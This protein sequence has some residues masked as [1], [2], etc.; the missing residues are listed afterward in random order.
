MS[1]SLISTCTTT[2]RQSNV[3]YNPTTYLSGTTPASIVLSLSNNA[4]V[5]NRSKTTLVIFA[6]VQSSLHMTLLAHTFLQKI[7]P[8]AGFQLFPSRFFRQKKTVIE[9]FSMDVPE[10]IGC[11]YFGC[12]ASFPRKFHSTHGNRKVSTFSDLPTYH[13]TVKNFG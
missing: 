12:C 11:T 13:Q 7:S 4:F 9:A 6:C 2:P 1:A 8:P 3:S 5:K 10:V